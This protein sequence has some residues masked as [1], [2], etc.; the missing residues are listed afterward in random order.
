MSSTADKMALSSIRGHVIGRW[1][2]GESR[3]RPAFDIHNTLSYTAADVMAA[4]Y[5]GDS[6]RVPKYIGFIYGPGNNGAADALPPITRDQSLSSIQA[7]VESIG[8][9]M[10]VVRFS[11]RPTVG[12][13][14]SFGMDDDRPGPE[15]SNDSSDS[16]DSSES[17]KYFGNIV[18]FHATTRPGRDGFYPYDPVIGSPYA[19]QLSDGDII[20][21]AVLLGD[22]LNPCEDDPYT[23][24]AMVD[25]KK[26]GAY[27]AKPDSYELALDWRVIFE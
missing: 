4:A 15:C 18:E 20:Y 24:L 19:D 6:R 13:Y 9:N 3:E 12:D 23:V 8:G 10:Q 7:L 26:N 22:G 21:R 2:S 16:S 14:T 11:R 17:Q 25:L 1:V 5:G 27:R